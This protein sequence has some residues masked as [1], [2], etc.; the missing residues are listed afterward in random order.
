MPE[1]LIQKLQPSNFKLQTS[2]FSCSLEES[3]MQHCGTNSNIL[4]H[5]LEI[6]LPAPITSPSSQALRPSSHRVLHFTNGKSFSIS[7]ASA[8][9]QVVC[10]MPVACKVFS[11]GAVPSCQASRGPGQHKETTAHGCQTLLV[12]VAIPDSPLLAPLAS[13]FERIFGTPLNTKAKQSKAKQ[14]MPA[15]KFTPKNE[16]CVSSLPVRT[17]QTSPRPSLG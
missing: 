9:A 8:K 1:L 2:N 17:L 5:R 12:N 4:L 6:E 3:P 16:A 15:S 7:L 11:N 13:K 10:A 14:S